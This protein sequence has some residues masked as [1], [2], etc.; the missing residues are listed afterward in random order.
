MMVLYRG[1]GAGCQLFK[2]NEP[3]EVTVPNVSP[4]YYNY[5][6]EY[7]TLPVSLA[8]CNC[9]VLVKADHNTLQIHRYTY[10][11]AGADDYTFGGFLCAPAVYTR[12]TS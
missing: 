12:V 5:P 1:A 3:V 10:Y 8:P 2:Y 4:F 7:I 6:G 11:H 9:L